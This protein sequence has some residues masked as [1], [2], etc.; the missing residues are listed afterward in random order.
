MKMPRALHTASHHPCIHNTQTCPSPNAQFIS[1]CCPCK[2]AFF[3]QPRLLGW[4]DCTPVASVQS[5]G[6]HRMQISV[7]YVRCTVTGETFMIIQ[8]AELQGIRFAGENFTLAHT[9]IHS[10]LSLSEHAPARWIQLFLSRMML[11]K[12]QVGSVINSGG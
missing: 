7:R 4:C 9:L 2:Q 1:C 11:Q 6:T 5:D 10:L 8:A 12:K 3:C